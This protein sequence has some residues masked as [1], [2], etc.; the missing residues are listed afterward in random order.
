MNPHI[1][2]NHNAMHGGTHNNFDD[3]M[4]VSN[5]NWLIILYNVNI[6][7]KL[8]IYIYVYILL[9]FIHKWFIT[10]IKHYYM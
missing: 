4:S 7:K 3:N 6:R 1:Y 10:I 9:F 8:F 5:Y 2:N